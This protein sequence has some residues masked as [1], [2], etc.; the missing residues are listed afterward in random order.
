MIET[1]NSIIFSPYLH[2]TPGA[3]PGLF[4]SLDIF[5]VVL[6]L[7]LWECPCLMLVLEELLFVS[8]D[9]VNDVCIIHV[10]SCAD[11]LIDFQTDQSSN[12]TTPT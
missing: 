10:F 6:F 8:Q 3:G 2:S 1:N 11:K 4:D 5:V 9:A 7:I 12:Q